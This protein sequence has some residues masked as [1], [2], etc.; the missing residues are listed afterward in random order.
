MKRC[1]CQIFSSFFS[2]CKLLPADHVLLLLLCARLHLTH[3]F[4]QKTLYRK[5]SYVCSTEHKK[6]IKH[7]FIRIFFINI[8]RELVQCVSRLGAWASKNSVL[9]VKSHSTPFFRDLNVLDSLLTIG[10][11]YKKKKF[12]LSFKTKKSVPF[13]RNIQIHLQ[14][15]FFKIQY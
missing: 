7:Y 11:F 2:T 10:I 15:S 1:H 14:L 12:E 6:S 4:L 8:V 3:C 13:W 9:G 5:E